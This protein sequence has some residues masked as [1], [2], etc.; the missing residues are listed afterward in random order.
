MLI[1]IFFILKRLEVYAIPSPPPFQKLSKS[2]KGRGEGI[3]TLS[4]K[5]LALT[6]SAKDIASPAGHC[7]TVSR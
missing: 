4:P 6:R 1:L 3:K 7:C 5:G 2:W